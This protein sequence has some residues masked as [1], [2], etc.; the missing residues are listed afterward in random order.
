MVFEDVVG[1]DHITKTLRNAIATGRISHSYIFS[2]A[3]GCGK[4]TTARILARAINCLHP[5]N[6]NPDND[7]ELCTE[8]LE[9]RSVNVFEIDGASNRGVDEIRNLREAVRYG[10]AKG[11]YK[12]YIIDEVHMLTKE[13]FNALLKTLEEPPSYIIFVFATTEIHKVPLTILSRCQRFDFRRISIKDI[14]DRLT[15]I[16]KKEKITVEND[17]DNDALTLIAKRADGSMRDAQSMFDQVV[18]YCGTKI[19]S[20]QIAEMWNIIDE[21]MYFRV[22]DAITGHD[23]KAGVLLAQEISAAGVDLREFLHGLIEHF[24]NI[25]VARV[26]NSTALIETSESYKKRYQE[27]AATLSEN[28]LLRLIKIASDIAASLRWSQQPRLSLELGIVQM[29]SLDSSVNIGKLLQDL[30]ELK[31]KVS[32]SGDDDLR[33]TS[34]PPGPRQRTEWADA[35]A[36]DTPP[37][38]KQFTTGRPASSGSGSEFQPPARPRIALAESLQPSSTAE[39][40]RPPATAEIATSAATEMVSLSADDVR[41]KWSSFVNETRRHRI[42]LWSMLSETTVVG[43]Q[44]EKVQIACP[45]DFHMDAL[46]RNRQFLTDLAQRVYG[47]RIVLETLLD[48]NTAQ[49][50]AQSGPAPTPEQSAADDALQQHPVVQDLKKEFGAVVIK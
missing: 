17:G 48:K 18:S 8:I 12:V 6:Q 10:P 41:G 39:I 25:L 22:T 38:R 33:A 5:N 29:T 23:T 20:K 36:H 32:D 1:Q 28:D 11:K 9:N 14:T 13:A 27:H 40:T 35:P 49:A 44:A 31:K 34:V 24:R 47:A 26:T 2:G 30:S 21:E 50:P 7:C 46:K 15:F 3:R 43:I 42:D 16:A 45:D 37:P 4:T 19:S